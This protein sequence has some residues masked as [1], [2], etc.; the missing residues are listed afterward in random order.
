M[1]PPVSAS[2]G[3]AAVGLGVDEPAQQLARDGGG[4]RGRVGVHLDPGGVGRGSR[5]LTGAVLPVVGNQRLGGGVLLG[6]RVGVAGDAGPTCWASCLPS[7]TPHWSKLSMPQTTP[8]MK[9]M[10][11]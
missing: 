11:S 4:Q 10:C 9:V 8:W 5:P 1:V 2:C 6:E 7:S 3:H